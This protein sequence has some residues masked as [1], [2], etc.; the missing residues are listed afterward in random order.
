[1]GKLSGQHLY[2]KGN[3]PCQPVCN[4]FIRKVPNSPIFSHFFYLFSNLSACIVF[5]RT[6]INYSPVEIAKML[7]RLAALRSDIKI[8]NEQKESLVRND[9]RLKKAFD[10]LRELKGSFERY[11]QLHASNRELIEHLKMSAEH[12]KT[13]S[14]KIFGK[15]SAI[16][17][18]IL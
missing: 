2:V 3:V 7:I 18:H 9:Y 17:T 6:M 16:P 12:H 15:H 13:L 11:R 4:G 10:D 1:M 8:L 14:A 5:Y